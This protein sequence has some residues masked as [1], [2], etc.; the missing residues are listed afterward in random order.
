V[1][2]NLK[3]SV[4][5]RLRWVKGKL[6]STLGLDAKLIDR[7]R[8]TGKPASYEAGQE[9]IREGDVDE[10]LFFIESGAVEARQGGK[11]IRRVE[12]GD[13][14]GEIAF[15]DRRPRTASVRAVGPVKV[16][17]LW[18]PDVLRALA[19]DP[20][21]L[22]GWVNA[23]TSRMRSRLE[24]TGVGDG[25][26]DE[27]LATLTQESKKHH[28][29]RHRYLSALA[30]GALPDLRWAMADF[31]RQY[32][33][34]SAHFP[35]YLAIVISRLAKPEHRAGL[36]KNLT[37]ESGI[38]EESE[39]RELAARGI[40]RDWISGIPHP[41]LIHRF[42]TALGMADT[43]I[44][45]DSDEVVCWREMFLA[46]LSGGSPAE[47]VGA[48]GLGTEGVVRDIYAPLAAAVQRLPEIAPRDA[49]FFPLHAA[50]DDHH[51][52]ALLDIARHYARTPEGRRDLSKG[53]R[54]ALALRASF[55]DWM[56]ERAVTMGKTD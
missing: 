30:E 49:V 2:K 25:G 15:L 56:Y 4:G 17:V 8:A 3:A 42:R 51:Q 41:T 12:A 6:M 39:L 7:V 53:M 1:N 23:I 19:D 54:K 37:Q 43:G 35:R 34:Y 21:T 48:L 27:F 11:V 13:V 46:V 31:G 20:E 10:R 44:E 29:V 45:D 36:L 55:W 40:D 22:M 52:A 18:R 47:A 50:I 16:V 38:Y 26:A 33:G 5:N 9:L 32:F 24:S 28:A 14:V